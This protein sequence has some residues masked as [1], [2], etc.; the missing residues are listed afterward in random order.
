M[1]TGTLEVKDLKPGMYTVLVERTGFE[2]ASATVEL[3]RGRRARLGGPGPGRQARRGGVAS[4]RR[5]PGPPRRPRRRA[6]R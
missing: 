6:R 3:K 2:T 5:G 1:G 4:A